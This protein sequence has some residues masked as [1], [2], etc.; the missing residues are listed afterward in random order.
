M[1]FLTR[2]CTPPD[3][4][5]VLWDD[6]NDSDSSAG[7]EPLI[8]HVNIGGMKAAYARPDNK[9][10]VPGVI[11]LHQL[12]GLDDDIRGVC[13]RFALQGYAAVAPSLYSCGFPPLCIVLPYSTYA[14]VGSQHES[15]THELG[16]RTADRPEVD[17]ARIGVIGSAWA[18]ALR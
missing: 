13:G 6:R 7:N 8:E 4:D 3:R 15:A 18:E 11:V 2:S 9:E 14:S 16:S 1:T 17:A 5:V 12:G 10:Q